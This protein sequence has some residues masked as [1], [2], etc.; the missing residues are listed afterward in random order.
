MFLLFIGSCTT[1][2]AKE[3]LLVKVTASVFL[4]YLYLS[5][6]CVYVNVTLPAM[7]PKVT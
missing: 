1:D 7:T 6:I 4:D 3:H 5:N 2:S